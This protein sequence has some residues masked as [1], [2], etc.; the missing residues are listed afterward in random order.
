MVSD[1][2]MSPGSAVEI[3]PL[4]NRDNE[5]GFR[6]VGVAV[7]LLVLCDV[8]SRVVSELLDRRLAMPDG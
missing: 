8:M 2:G 7:I 5:F 6:G 1:R 4:V 3:H